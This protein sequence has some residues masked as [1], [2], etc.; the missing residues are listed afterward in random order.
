MYQLRVMS[1]LHQGSSLR[2]DEKPYLIGAGGHSG[3]MLSDRGIAAVHA[4]ALLTDGVCLLTAVDGNIGPADGTHVCIRLKPGQCVQI[5]PVW[6]AL[7]GPALEP[8]LAL[9]VVAAQLTPARPDVAAAL[10]A[11]P[12]KR[13]WLSAVLALTIVTAT[14]AYAMHIGSAVPVTSA[15]AA[16]APPAAAPAPVVALVPG[17]PRIKPV[18]PGLIPV[19]S[20]QQL[21]QTFRERLESAALLQRFTLDLQDQLW[22]MQANLDDDELKRFERVLLAFVHEFDIRFPFNAKIGSAEDLL[23]FKVQQVIFGDYPSLVTKDGQRLF[24]GDE[25]RGFRLTSIAAGRLS[26]AGKRKLVMNW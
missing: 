4:L 10:P 13:I 25:Y 5:G 3:L 2:L 15:S 7:S 24:V 21:R 16:V 9:P 12:A 22:A 14:A 19:L 6:L 20:Q 8:G 26:F 11:R 18:V 23:P 1:G 17:T